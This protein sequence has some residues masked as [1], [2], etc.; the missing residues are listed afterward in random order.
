MRSTEW[1]SGGSLFL[2]LD[3][4]CVDH[5]WL[6]WVRDPS[7]RLWDIMV[8]LLGLSYTF[9]R[10]WN[11][12]YWG[13]IVYI[14][15]A[16]FLRHFCAFILKS[17]EATFWRL[18][19]E[20]KALQ[21]D[22]N[23]EDPKTWNFLLSLISYFL[24]CKTK[25]IHLFKEK[26]HIKFFKYWEIHQWGLHLTCTGLLLQV[27]AGVLKRNNQSVISSRTQVASSFWFLLFLAFSH[28]LIGWLFQINY[29]II[30]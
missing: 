26:T 1:N 9:D 15:E 27:I 19:L 17:E 18:L 12:R 21:F 11:Q 25:K 24:Y 20:I 3:W 14:F 5:F 4:N 16:M 30:Y 8:Q 13:S 10:T 7:L 6:F 29:C 28:R 22:C 23:C 2:T